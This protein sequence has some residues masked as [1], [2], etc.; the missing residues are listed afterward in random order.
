MSK[1]GK[2]TRRVLAQ[3]GNVLGYGQFNPFPRTQRK[4]KPKI[5]RTQPDWE[6]SSSLEFLTTHVIQQRDTP[7]FVLQIGAFDGDFDDPIAGLIRKYGWR[8]LLVEPQP[9]AF[10][11]LR[12]NY[13]DQTQLTF[14]N[15]AIGDHDGT[16]KLYT[17]KDATSPLASFE[18]RHLVRHA[19][20][21]NDII[22]HQVCSLTL[23]SLLQR[24]G[25]QH[26][27]LLQ[28]D[29]EGYDGQIIRSIDSSVLNP[30][31]I[32]YEH[33]NLLE[34]ERCAC[35]ELLA[36][37]GYRFLLE[38]SDTIAYHDAQRAAA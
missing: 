35:I 21:P 19:Q 6:I 20:Q 12:K 4:A 9:R 14:E 24:H 10:E 7:F 33:A 36:S 29:V 22:E 30:P 17:M 38:D 16:V 2:E 3:F 8:G 23:S 32:R 37:R 15:A 28:I 1:I 34:A 27:D 13:S 5:L 18:H 26:V 31:I 25:I 11:Q